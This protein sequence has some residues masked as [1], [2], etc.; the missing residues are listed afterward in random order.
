MSLNDTFTIEMNVLDVVRKAALVKSSLETIGIQFKALASESSTMDANG[1]ILTKTLRGMDVEGNK[2]TTTLKNIDGVMKQVGQSVVLA[3]EKFID[4]QKEYTRLVQSVSTTKTSVATI[5]EKEKYAKAKAALKQFLQDTQITKQQLAAVERDIAA[6]NFNAYAN[7]DQN[8]LRALIV[9]KYKAIENLGKAHQDNLTK[10]QK[11]GLKAQLDAQKV[12]DKQVAESIKAANAD[13]ANRAKIAASQRK[14]DI[15]NQNSLADSLEPGGTG[16]AGQF[17]KANLI[18]GSI[19]RVRDALSS[20]TSEAIKFEQTIARV[21]TLSQSVGNSTREWS[22]SVMELSRAYGSDARQTAEAYYDALSNQVAKTQ[23][24]LERFTIQAVELAQVTGSTVPQAGNILSSAINAFGKDVSRAGEIS[25]KTFKMIDLGRINVN[26]LSDSLGRTAVPA[27]VLGVTMDEL[28]ASLATLTVQGVSTADA[29]TQMLNL[30]NKLIKPSEELQ[31]HLESLGFESGQQAVQVLGFTGVLKEL[32][33][34]LANGGLAQLGKELNDIRGFRGAIG[35][36]GKNFETYINYLDQ[37]R[38]AQDSYANATKLVF[39]N[40]GKI[41]DKE[42]NKIKTNFLELGQKLISAFVEVN[43]K[44]GGFANRLKTA[45]EVGTPLA[46]GLLTLK[47]ASMGYAAALA[48]EARAAAAA[49]AG[50]TAHAAAIRSTTLAYLATPWGIVIAGLSAVTAAVSYYVL[51]YET[52]AEKHKRL[53]DDLV[54][55]TREDLDREIAAVNQAGDARIARLTEAARIEMKVSADRKAAANQIILALEDETKAQK[56]LLSLAYNKQGSFMSEYVNALEGDLNKLTSLRERSANKIKSINQDL[57]DASVQ[58]ALEGASTRQAFEI[59]QKQFREAIDD[60]NKARKAG[61]I[62]AADEALDSAEKAGKAL[63]TL[64]RQQRSEELSAEKALETARKNLRTSTAKNKVGLE[65]RVDEAEENL[66]L[67]KSDNV[68]IDAARM[69]KKIVEERA[70]LEKDI[71]AKQEEAADKLLKKQAEAS[72]KQMVMQLNIEELR[73]IDKG[74]MRAD[75]TPEQA[76]ARRKGLITANANIMADIGVG[77][78]W[79]KALAKIFEDAT[80]TTEKLLKQTQMKEL[81]DKEIQLRQQ[82]LDIAT[83]TSRGLDAEQNKNLEAINKLTA[84]FKAASELFAAPGDWSYGYKTPGEIRDR[85]NRKLVDARLDETDTSNIGSVNDTINFIRE[86]IKLSNDDLG[87]NQYVLDAQQAL[88]GL[89]AM[90]E[91]RDATVEQIKILEAAATAATRDNTVEVVANLVAVRSQIA[92]L[93]D[94]PVINPATRAAG[95][96]IHGSD[97]IMIG[98]SE[99]VMNGLASQRFAPQLSYMNSGMWKFGADRGSNVSVGDVNVSINSTGN[100]QIDAVQI[101]QAIRREI[102][103]GTLKL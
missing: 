44:I 84:S 96:R 79:Q 5:D 51:S 102:K 56:G 55:A 34:T 71:A 73:N 32:D 39:E 37:V 9:A 77:S 18:L 29:Q 80:G 92:L 41:V 40:N 48:A 98:S 22:D 75:E 52:A 58:E 10:I 17:V 30:M 45:I 65:D 12:H 64:M 49:A 74:M 76:L 7:A 21:Q 6:G 66:K 23:G 15:A 28:Y 38:G 1:A 59:Y 63:Q 4:A 86:A 68:R 19:N 95:G 89:K 35:L 97:N 69:L 25:A 14:A 43:D 8:K 62:V 26:D 3:K 13:L 83:R 54:N 90:L 72:A 94:D 67:V 46:T 50:H 47:I 70:K 42:L 33:K 101:G 91:A 20:G 87:N 103:R 24:D 82:V 31:K 81:S 27:Q 2:V 85:D 99:Y 78:D 57:K 88:Y 11:D 53:T 93:Q 16:L 36:L 60:A 100:Q 61:D